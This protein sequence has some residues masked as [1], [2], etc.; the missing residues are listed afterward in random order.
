[1]RRIWKV[2]VAAFV[3]GLLL[4][5]PAGVSASSGS[6]T[7]TLVAE[8]ANVGV[9]PSGETVQ[10]SCETTEGV[11]GTFGVHPKS[12]TAS[13]EFQHFD[14]SGNLLASGTWTATELLSFHA[15]GCGEVFG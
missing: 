9:A 7:Y 10:I 12:I 3:A 8:G 15:Y 2:S 13:G 14:A 11:C 4:L 1:M 5:V 6:H